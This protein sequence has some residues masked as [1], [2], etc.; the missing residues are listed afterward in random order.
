MKV[1]EAIA[2]AFVLEGG[3]AVFGLL[4]D[5]NMALWIGL[6]ARPKIEIFSAR[7][8]AGAV[9]MADGYFRATGRVGIAT[10]TSGPGLTQIGT[11]LTA[12]VRNGSALVVA[13]GDVSMADRNNVQKFDQR[14]FVEAC[15]AAFVNV[16]GAGNVAQEVAE[17]F[18]TARMR[19]QPVVLNMPADVQEQSFEWDFGYEPAKNHLPAAPATPSAELLDELVGRL[20][21]AERPVLLAGIGAKTAGA[22]AELA[23]LGERVGALL[24]TT[25]K[26]KGFF[27]GEAY[28]VGIAGAFASAPTEQLLGEADFVLGIGAELGYYTTEGGLLFPGAEVARIDHAPFPKELGVLPGLYLQGDAN[29]TVQAINRVLAERGEQREGYRTADTRAVLDAPPAAIDKATDGMD[30]RALAARIGAALPSNA[31][32]TIGCGHFWAFFHMYTP[33]RADLPLHM[34]YQFGSI[35][36][37][38]PIA[39]GVSVAHPDRPHLVIEGDGSVMMHIQELETFARHG[40]PAVVL[41][42]NDAGFGAEVHKLKAKKADEQLGRW[43]KSPDF[44]TVARG[45]G[46]EG[47]R[48]EREEDLEAA[49]KRGFASGGLYLLDVRVSPSTISDPYLKLQFGV[50]NRAPLLRGPKR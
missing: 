23:E 39:L 34:S 31:V 49:L 4:G 43:A 22:G 18:Y 44:V 9:A 3:E 29:A 7:H 32:V 19:R 36:Q 27:A 14:R 5:A 33:V 35:G 2:E 28:D 15:G 20:L 48:V 12:A 38:L 50:E 26:A 25:L 13:V 30:P 8:E 41:V 40:R 45:F 17:A 10:I 21:Q 46:G 37:T 6:A 1:S 16:T 11:S 47:E 42:W 24:A